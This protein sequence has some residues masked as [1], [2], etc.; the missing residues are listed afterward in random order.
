MVIDPPDSYLRRPAR[1]CE[2]RIVCRGRNRSHYAGARTATTSI[3]WEQPFSVPANLSDRQVA[4][5]VVRLLGLSLAT[6]VHDFAIGHDA[7]GRLKLDFYHANGRHQVT[8][9]E[10]PVRLRVSHTRAGFLRYLSTLHVTTAAFHS[11]DWRM[12]LWAWW[13]EFAMWCVAVMAASGV[14]IWWERRRK[15]PCRD[16]ACIPGC[17]VYTAIRRSARSLFWRYTKSAPCRWRTE[18]G[19]GPEPCSARS[20]ASI[21]CAGSVCLRRW[22]CHS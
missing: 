18:R 17:F 5:R 10:H 16:V 11:G 14:W 19:S 1:V 20:T 22:E 2:F 6:P 15:R 8:L 3:V 21:V 4:E 9:L 7:E 12:Q 13:N